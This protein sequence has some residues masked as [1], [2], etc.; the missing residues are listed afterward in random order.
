MKTGT[1]AKVK[2]KET[3]VLS[4]A[5]GPAAGQTMYCF[6]MAIQTD[7]EM[8]I[9]T[10][11]SK[12]EVYPMAQGDEINV[13]VTTNAYGKKFKKVNPQYAEQGGK[14]GQDVRGKC[15]CQVIKAGINSSQLKCD[16]L[17]DVNDW[18]DVMMGKNNQQATG[19]TDYGSGVNDDIPF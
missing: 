11:N 15:L 10:I 2:F 19:S 13:E 3:F 1:I 14:S 5:A 17:E 9:G 6:D 4:S 12:S 18:A 7:N 16:C 8:L